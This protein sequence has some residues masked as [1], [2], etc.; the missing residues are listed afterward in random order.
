MKDAE[1]QAQMK[2]ELREIAKA[3]PKVQAAQA[4]AV[5]QPWHRRVMNTVGKMFGR[6]K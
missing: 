4:K 6:N 5:Q 1:E 3:K 2:R